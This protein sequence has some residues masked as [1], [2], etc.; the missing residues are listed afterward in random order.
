MVIETKENLS[1]KITCIQASHSNNLVAVGAGNGVVAF[2]S[3]IEN[4]FVSTALKYHGNFVTSLVFSP[5]D[6][7]VF[8]AAYE[9]VVYVWDT[10]TLK[11]ADKIGNIGH[12]GAINHLSLE[13]NAFVSVGT[14]AGVKKW[15][16]AV[17]Q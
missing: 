12:R 8:S 11:K 1:Q 7:K 13:G 17:S 14:D 5:D 4:K 6:S 10:A 2:Y 3:N 15:N 9:P 16:Y